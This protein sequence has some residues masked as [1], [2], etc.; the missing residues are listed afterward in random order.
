MFKKHEK[1]ITHLF[2]EK[3]YNFLESN[4][5][6]PFNWNT[7]KF[8][9]SFPLEF[10]IKNP[11]IQFQDHFNHLS[12]NDYFTKDKNN[13]INPYKYSFI[14]YHPG[15]TIDLLKKYP[16]FNFDWE[17][18]NQ[19]MK[20]PKNIL[21]KSNND[22]ID[23]I[24]TEETYYFSKSIKDMNFSYNFTKLIYIE[25]NAFLH[26]MFYEKKLN[27]S[28]IINS[29]NNIETCQYKTFKYIL[30]IKDDKNKKYNWNDISF[31][32]YVF[33]YYIVKLNYFALIIQNWW[34]D[35]LLN[36]YTDLGKKFLNNKFNK[37]NKYNKN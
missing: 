30:S 17:F 13:K 23:Y 18:I 31:D 12:Y 29:Y 20:I 11:S 21:N 33:E 6:L 27:I 3:F 24:N 7:L 36:P 8:N 22:L 16:K 5:N 15:L 4:S 28:D 1:E 26:Y 14:S 19:N 2:N 25:L 35:H 10:A 37:I 9:I 34:K 32:S